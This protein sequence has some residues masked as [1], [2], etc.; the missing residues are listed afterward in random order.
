[1][2]SNSPNAR[3]AAYVHPFD[4]PLLLGRA[5]HTDRRG[6]GK[7]RRLLTASSPASAVVACLRASSPGFSETGSSHVPVI[8]VETEGAESFHA[9]LAANEAYHLAG[10]HLDR[11]FVSA[12]ARWRSMSSICRSITRS[13]A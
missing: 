6:C 11:Q 5:R 2:R 4:H 9:S 10:H 1:M 8:A 3:K 12:R 7:G 13:K